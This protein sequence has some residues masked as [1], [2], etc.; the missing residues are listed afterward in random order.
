MCIFM[1]D[2][3]GLHAEY[4]AAR[5]QCWPMRGV[6]SENVQHSSINASIFIE[7]P[8]VLACVRRH[9]EC[10][11]RLTGDLAVFNPYINRDFLGI[12][13]RCIRCST[14]I[15]ALFAQSHAPPAAF[16]A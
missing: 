2:A 1:D 10:Q 8:M 15:P 14:R 6:K 3:D 7:R 12:D 16:K 4:G 5:R 9:V 11:T 13:D